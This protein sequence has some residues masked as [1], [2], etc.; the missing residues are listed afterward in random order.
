MFSASTTLR[1]NGDRYIQFAV[2]VIDMT[3]EG[4]PHRGECKMNQ[5]SSG[6]E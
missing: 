1:I 2:W 4:I 3:L 5:V 6:G